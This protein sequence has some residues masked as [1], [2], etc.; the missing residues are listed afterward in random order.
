MNN[1]TNNELAVALCKA[2]KAFRVARKG[3]ANPFFKSKY[4]SFAEVWEAVAEGL[5]END[6]SILQPIQTQED[7]KIFVETI[8]MHKSGQSLTSHCP[9]L[10][11]DPTNPQAMGSA[12]TYARRYSLAALLGVVIDD[13]DGNTAAQPHK[14]AVKAEKPAPTNNLAE[15][16]EALQ[17]CTSRAEFEAAQRKYFAA[18]KSNAQFLEACKEVAKKYPKEA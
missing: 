11:K 15:A 1:E 3:T 18:N 10:T 9:V 14:P 6:L 2:Q 4:A 5:Q 8:I 16:L 12:I 13:D 17:A 7:G